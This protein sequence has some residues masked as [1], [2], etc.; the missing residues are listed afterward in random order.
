LQGENEILKGG[1]ERSA[2]NLLVPRCFVWVIEIK[3]F[4]NHPNIAWDSP[5]FMVDG[6]LP[7]AGPVTPK[8]LSE[9]RSLR[10][11]NHIVLDVRY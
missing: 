10:K 7:E 9:G 11:K 5:S 3:I 6:S 4:C 2:S 8:L 1:V